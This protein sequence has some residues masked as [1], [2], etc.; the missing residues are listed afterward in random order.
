MTKIYSKGKIQKQIYNILND[1]FN[2]ETD[3]KYNHDC[4]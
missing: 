3:M 4:E 1:Q 2:E